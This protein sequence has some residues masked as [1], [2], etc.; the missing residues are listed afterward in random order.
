M[1]SSV[2][3]TPV[4]GA[5]GRRQ[6]DRMV[7]ACLLAVSIATGLVRQQLTEQDT[8]YLRP[9]ASICVPTHTVGTH[10]YISGLRGGSTACVQLG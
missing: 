10:W 4:L 9:Q 1:A 6:R 3:V 5:G 2:P 8:Q 7:Q